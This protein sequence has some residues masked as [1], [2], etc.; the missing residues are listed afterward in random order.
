MKRKFTLFSIILS[1][2][3]LSSL[4]P[5]ADTQSG[6]SKVP[7]GQSISGQTPKT[8]YSG[9]EPKTKPTS[10]PSP[11]PAETEKTPQIAR[12]LPLPSANP[13]F[14]PQV[15]FD[16]AIYT[17]NDL[18]GNSSRIMR[19]YSDAR[20]QLGSLINRYPKDPRLVLTAALLDE[21]LENFDQSVKEMNQYV[22]LNSDS[23][24][25]LRR[26]ANFYHNRALFKEQVEILQKVA[27]KLRVEE[28]E[29]IYRE[30]I[31]VVKDHEVK[32]FSI[33]AIYKE[34]LDTDKQNVGLVK[35]YVDELTLK[36]R[37]PQ[38][39]E[40]LNTYQDKYPDELRYFLQK[41]ASIY[42]EQ[43][44]RVKAEAVYKEAFDPLWSNDITTDYYEL[45]RKIGRYRNYRRS[46]QTEVS[47]STSF[48]QT[49][50]L[51]SL[52]AYEQNNP[53]AFN[54]LKNY[55]KKR[56]EQANWKRQE[57]ETLAGLFI[58]IGQY[59][60]S[61][62]YLY[63]LYLSE[64]LKT[65]SLER[66]KYLFK[67]FKILMDS[68][69]QPVSL[70][71][72]DLSLYRD[73]AKV[74]Q[75]PGLLN[76]VLS[77]ILSNTNLG[78]EFEQKEN[79]AAS[80]FNRSFAYRIFNNFK[81]EYA[82]SDRL[83]LMYE[84]LMSM[85]AGFGEHKLVI[86]LGKEFQAKFPNAPNYQQTTIKI[87]NSLVAL[88]QRE[89]ERTLLIQ[90]LDKTAEK[91]SDRVLLPSSRTV[92]SPDAQFENVVDEIIRDITF[93]S[94]T[95]NP[96][97]LNKDNG[98]DNYNVNYNTYNQG[99]NVN[100][101]TILERI[102]SSY[103]TEGK[104]QETLKFFWGEI[105]KHPKEEGLYERMLRWLESA[106]LLNEQFKV[107]TAALDK[108]Q[109]NT[110][111]NRLAR[112]YI[113]NKK[114]AEFQSY[115]KEVIE[116]FDQDDIKEYLNHFAAMNYNNV[117]DVN[118]DSNLYFQLYSYA[119]KRFPNN[120]AFV[121]GLLRYYAIQK[122]W[123]EWEKLSFQYYSFDPVI[124]E[125]LLRYLA[126]NKRLKDVYD[127]ARKNINTSLSYQ[128]FSADAAIKLS[129]Y[130]E[131]LDTYKLLVSNYPGETQYSLKLADLM[132]SYAYQDDKYSEESAKVYL[133][134]A[135]I[136][137]TNHDYKTKAGEV[138]A[139]MSD[140]TR[141]HQ[142]WDS[143]LATE[144]GVANTYL[145]V[146]SIYWDYF[147]FDDAARVIK[148]YRVNSGDKTALAYK[149]GA[150]YEG[151]NDWKQA[152]NEYVSVLDENGAGRDVV[153]KR[154]VQLAPRRD[155][156][157][158]IARSYEQQA[159]SNPSNWLLTLGYSEYLRSS[160]RDTDADN[161]LRDQVAKRSELEFLETIRDIFHRERLPQD[162]EQTIIRLTQLAR[163]EREIMK[164]RLQ[165]ALFYEQKQDQKAV[166]VFDKL[167]TDYPSNLGI[168]Q[169]ASQYYSRAGLTDKAIALFKDSLGRAKGDYQRQFTL[170]LASRLEKANKLDEAE[171]ILRAWYKDHPLDSEF[172]RNL[173]AVLGKANKQD[174]LVELYQ[175]GL[176]QPATNGL[177]GDEAKAYIINLRL[178]MIETLI[179]LNRPS[180]VVD[181]YIEVINRQFDNTS[182]IDAAFRYA[183]ANNQLE[184]FTRYYEDTAKKSYK[185]YRWNL[186]LAA[187]YASNG[188]VAKEID[189]YK[190]ALTNEPQRLDLRETLANLYTREQRFDEATAALRRN[191]E[192]DGNNPDWLTKIAKV[193]IQAG[194]PDAAVAT[195]RDG[196]SRNPKVTAQLLFNAGKLLS[197]RAYTKQAFDFYK[198]AIALIKAK[199]TKESIGVDDFSNYGLALLKSTSPLT[200]YQEIKSLETKLAAVPSEEDEKNYASS[201]KYMVESFLRDKFGLQVLAICSPKERLDLAN[202]LI[203]S[204]KAVKGFDTD[205]EAEIRKLLSMADTAG[206]TEA[207]ENILLKMKELS[208]AESPS[209]YYNNVLG[210]LAFYD[211]YGMYS[212]AAD[213]LQ[214]EKKLG[215][216]KASKDENS[217]VDWERSYYEL[218]SEYLHK[219]GLAERE[220]TALADYYRTRSGSATTDNNPLIQRYLS[221]LV[222][223]N[224]KDE[225]KQLSSKS[226]P[227]QLQLINFLIL[228]REKDLALQAIDS[229]PF[230]NAWKAS[231]RG[232]VGLYFQ[233]T[234]SKVEGAFLSA[235]DVD[236]IGKQRNQ[237]PNEE[238][239][240][241]GSDWY[242]AA[243]NYGVWLSLTTDKAAQAHK[244][245]VARVE[246][247][248]KDAI[249]Q[250]ELANFYINNKVFNLAE[251]HLA[252]ASELAPNS[253]AIQVAQGNYFFMRGEREKALNAWN[254][255]IAKRNAGLTQYNSYFDALATHELTAQALP[256]VGRFLSRAVSRLSW[257]ELSP[258]I[259]K[260]A[261]ASKTPV[262]SSAVTD[263]FYQVIRDNPN[264]VKLGEMLLQEDLITSIEGKTA[265]YRVM[266]ERY[267]D[268]LLATNLS[269][270]L[271]R[272][273][274]YYSSE[275]VKTLLDS[276]EKRFIDF[277]IF[278]RQFDQA[279][280][281]LRY[282]QDS[283]QE[284]SITITP[285]WME[286]AQA[287]IDLRTN[288]VTN[289]LN[290]LHRYVGLTNDSQQSYVSSD[291]YL[292]AYTLLVNEKQNEVAD[293]LLYD[294]YQSQLRVG[295][296]TI[297][298]YT[299]IAG[300]EFRRG[301]NKEALNWLQK[302]TAIIG[303]AEA[304]IE[305]GK[306]AERYGLHKEA[307]DWRDKGAKLDPSQ[308]E[309]RLELARNAGLIGQNQLGINTLKQL[310]ESRETNNTIRAQAVELIPLVAGTK[311]NALAAL[312]SFQNNP[313]Y[314][315][316]L[317]TAGLLIAAD[318][319]PEARVILQQA[320]KITTAAQ[321]RL[322]LAGLEVAEKTAN[323]K[324]AL[325]DALYA[326]GK[327]VVSEAIAFNL[328][329]PR[330]RLVQAFVAN[331][332]LNA[333]L[334]FSPIQA[335]RTMLTDEG[336]A[337]YSSQYNSDDDSTKSQSDLHSFNYQEIDITAITSKYLTLSELASTRKKAI[338]KELLATLVDVAVKVRD[339]TQAIE[340]LKL[341]QAKVNNPE[342]FALLDQKRKELT[343]QVTSAQAIEQASL[344]L[345]TELTQS[346][347][348]QLLTQTISTQTINVSGEGL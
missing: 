46:L 308:A 71:R 18:F 279:R 210:L 106:N 153:I 212:K 105:K 108:F 99:N 278:Q 132:R 222:E 257:D 294:Y 223:L 97:W 95:Y 200:A 96:V 215:R 305:A 16:N 232:Q 87:A 39:L 118:Y 332:Q 24:G 150:I 191:F 276:Q 209:K 9:K 196:L 295:Q 115:S 41:R 31:S 282:M 58:S 293:Q 54:L 186:V 319:K 49:T 231:R 201:S 225:L 242:V 74:D 125:N 160:G 161:L 110:W 265:L 233:D 19:S 62:R 325:Q 184:R 13:D 263:M 82:N 174:A 33:E 238:K 315:S 168:I 60:E 130:N 81:Q 11:K 94:D 258:F 65:G 17:T 29:P 189:Q 85:F 146:A 228:Q 137:P 42:Q 306:L 51:F 72:G 25:A 266:L 313:D 326:D 152:I 235:L 170:Q 28:R 53:L 203:Q 119:L 169:E 151:K 249:A 175:T 121:N 211:R 6:L 221:L 2:L 271:Y 267:Q 335:K 339:L 98:N 136:Y 166:Q 229:S 48:D 8:K 217:S 309:N 314:Y 32:G 248:P 277:L 90:L 317:I 259:R 346:V 43:N 281:N 272:D 21:R 147:Q 216:W 288:N 327:G 207:E 111:S 270:G 64:G 182:I 330:S 219:A 66:E 100:Y 320:G 154:L 199:P 30:I 192:I 7:A 120:I 344:K 75:N 275:Q 52:Y 283:H 141:A 205:N 114:R 254:S 236:T 164:Y 304:S 336:E 198:E 156:A 333:A 301:H 149:L 116:V 331:N 321:A 177:S 226:N 36:R 322:I 12:V 50:R 44:D 37:Y 251:Q 340:L 290:S 324:T 128:L 312:P 255:L 35:S 45:L 107:Y 123:T 77:L 190:L 27:A 103:G 76:G 328:D 178:A 253:A 155:F 256:A 117:S 224:K 181:Q 68:S 5:Q 220:V 131:A 280:Q 73:I 14:A 148:D 88:G 204:A 122:N 291:R 246:D 133:Q 300:V 329:D 84:D 307:F 101:S 10:T 109:D 268:L 179:K 102:V 214:A 273:N 159:N 158:I 183:Q 343:R 230:S 55:E 286:M 126:S 93:F 38:A 22:G 262:L 318:R 86:S 23:I 341:Y 269:G 47:R 227:Y 234:S 261:I 63:T 348:D 247:K 173:V 4:S 206:L 79:N 289:A 240:L 237:T 311:E 194:K 135:R 180:E 188:E 245:I 56:G 347:L 243:S 316:Q 195:L 287:V 144:Q 61:S 250:L 26:L 274:T 285:E 129:H 20:K 138:F 298:N 165:L 112:W 134:L 40:V 197:D 91:N 145:E 297:A 241:I 124:R 113:R 172:F 202:N 57:L 244:Y 193:Q 239:V 303:S 337:D 89:T 80:Y 3:I 171:Q 167:L 139:D 34:L 310:I 213:M 302:M 1:V 218:V 176:K 157:Q 296:G 83:P 163:D 92:S 15:D 284:L 140:F 334:A 345:G 342:Q 252:L 264:N 69:S 59:D 67:L 299:G 208:F 127:K 260:V 162:E 78:Y 70:S 187:I 323:A 143:I 292:K 142:A 185:D 338:D 104:K